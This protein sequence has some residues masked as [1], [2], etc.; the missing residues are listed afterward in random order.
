MPFCALLQ[1]RHLGLGLAK[2]RSGPPIM[3]LS[4]LDGPPLLDR[5]NTVQHVPTLV[6]HSSL[7]GP[8]ILNSSSEIHLPP[9]P[10]LSP[11]REDAPDPQS[12]AHYFLLSKPLPPRPATADPS[13]SR[14]IPRKPIR[15]H[16]DTTT[17]HDTASRSSDRLRRAPAQ[18]GRVSPPEEL[19]LVQ[20]YFDR[21]HSRSPTSLSPPVAAPQPKRSH[22]CDPLSWLEEEG[23]WEVPRRWPSRICNPSYRSL[24]RSSMSTSFSAIPDGWIHQFN[25]VQNANIRVHT[26]SAEGLPPPSYDSHAFSPTYVMRMQDGPIPGFATVSGLVPD[27]S[28]S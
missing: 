24:S 18:R 8:P 3:D 5:R 6:D 9:D 2:S 23:L 17:D 10:T 16:I 1:R 22:T 12:D 27:V 4:S 25:Q 14:Q 28:T 21:G 7:D 13:S 19:I 11:I 20:E 15:L 26:D